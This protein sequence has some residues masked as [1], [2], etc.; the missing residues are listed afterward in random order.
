VKACVGCGGEVTRRGA[1]GPWPQRCLLCTATEQA[2][3]KR[4][5]R[6]RVKTEGVPVHGYGGYANGCR[7]E[8]CTQ[9]K[10]EYVRQARAEGRVIDKR[11]HHDPRAK[12]YTSRPSL[13]SG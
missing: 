11:R 12:G 1:R 10:R 8:V 4:V 5:Y 6:E 7:C 3:H 9:A 13:E 2:Q